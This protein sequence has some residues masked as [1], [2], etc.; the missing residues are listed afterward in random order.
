[1]GKQPV[2]KFQKR[3]QHPPQGRNEKLVRYVS[4]TMLEGIKQRF[5]LGVGGLFYLSGPAAVRTARAIANSGNLIWEFEGL[6]FVLRARIRTR[7]CKVRAAKYSPVPGPPAP[8]CK[9][10]YY[11][12]HSPTLLN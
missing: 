2:K 7:V 8:G 3:P 12:M 6:E 5:D 4:K 1:M 11:L 9:R 10:I